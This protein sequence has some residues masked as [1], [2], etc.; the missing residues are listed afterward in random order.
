MNWKNILHLAL[1]TSITI[2]ALAMRAGGN[3]SLAFATSQYSWKIAQVL[4]EWDEQKFI[5]QLSRV[6]VKYGTNSQVSPLFTLQEF[7]DTM[8]KMRSDTKFRAFLQAEWFT[9]EDLQRVM[10]LIELNGDIHNAA[11]IYQMMLGF[12]SGGMIMFLYSLYEMYREKNP[13]DYPKGHRE[14]PFTVEDMAKKQ[15]EYWYI[16]NQVIFDVETGKMK[17]FDVVMNIVPK[18]A[19]SVYVMRHLISYEIDQRLKYFKTLSHHLYEFP[20][21]T[22]I[23]HDLRR[24]IDSLIN[25]LTWDEDPDEV[26]KNIRQKFE[27]G[28]GDYLDMVDVE[29][30]LHEQDCKDFK[31]EVE[32]RYIALEKLNDEVS[33]NWNW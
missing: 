4:R 23:T 26:E 3:K 24:E 19:G 2:G 10:K 17:N 16:L 1:A 29:I 11:K 15:V 9:E 7:H 12:A 6:A 5:A 18:T 27:N 22:K 8:T 13:M 21:A 28:Q 31:R 32:E 33:Q 30:W 14:N 20:E 25:E